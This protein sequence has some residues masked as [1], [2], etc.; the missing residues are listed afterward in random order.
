VKEGIDQVILTD[1]EKYAMGTCIWGSMASM[2]NEFVHAQFMLYHWLP[3]GMVCLTAALEML[4]VLAT[5][6]SLKFRQYLL[7]CRYK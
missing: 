7:Q 6:P 1:M 3:C 2:Y 5:S 4:N